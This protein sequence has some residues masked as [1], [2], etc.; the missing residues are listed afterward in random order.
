MSCELKVFLFLQHLN[1]AEI[2][3]IIKNVM[4]IIM[5]RII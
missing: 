1:C 4:C 2:Y 3:A 5:A